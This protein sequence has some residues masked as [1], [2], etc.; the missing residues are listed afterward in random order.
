MEAVLERGEDVCGHEFSRSV[1]ENSFKCQ[2][3]EGR[4]RSSLILSN[5]GVT[6]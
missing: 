1:G 4:T 6:S 2:N 5:G 3:P